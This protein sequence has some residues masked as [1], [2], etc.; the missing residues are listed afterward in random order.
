M[1]YVVH[2]IDVS[3]VLFLGKSIWESTTNTHDSKF[4]KQVGSDLDLTSPNNCW[5]RPN[6][7]A[8]HC[9]LHWQINLVLLQ[10]YG[11]PC[12]SD[13]LLSIACAYLAH[14][15]RIWLQPNFSQLHESFACVWYLDCGRL[16]SIVNAVPGLIHRHWIQFE[17]FLEGGEVNLLHYLHNDVL[18]Q[19]EIIKI[20][21]FKVE[22]HFP[23]SKALKNLIVGNILYSL[24]KTLERA[25]VEF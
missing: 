1:Y 17:G 6:Q 21:L 7:L 22:L 2:E 12:V 8:Q 10:F 14:T 18:F 25:T 15:L 3:R 19:F 16:G 13:R 11:I 23:L 5:S 20:K 24:I 4:S 9:F